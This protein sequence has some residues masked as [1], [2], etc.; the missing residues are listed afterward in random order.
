MFSKVSAEKRSTDDFHGTK[1]KKP[2]A[3]KEQNCYSA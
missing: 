1:K 2:R 3:M